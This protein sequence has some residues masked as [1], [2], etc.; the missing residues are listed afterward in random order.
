MS[1]TM[2]K[3]K[4]IGTVITT[5]IILIASVVLGAGVIFFGGSLFQNNTNDEAIQISNAHI[6]VAPNNGTT[7][8]AA[9][10]VQNTGGK[11]VSIHSV[12]IRGMS[13]P[14]DSWYYN[15]VDATAANVLRE[16]R[17]DFNL[18]AIDVTG[19]LPEEVFVHATAPVTITQGQ[20]VI[21]YVAN[22]GSITAMDSNLAFNVS[23]HA[24]KASTSLAGVDVING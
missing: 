15:T 2:R 10:V 5:L 18:N 14:I 8:V 3:R 23:V 11:V 6:W 24:G 16:L 19:T 7:S 9:F 20:A 12:T 17:S 22:P 21:V 4:G 1:L 13:V